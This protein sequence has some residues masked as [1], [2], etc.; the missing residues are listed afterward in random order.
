MCLCP[1]TIKNPHYDPC[2]V[3]TE[4][5]C[6]QRK[7][8]S[9]GDYAVLQSMENFYNRHNTHICVPCGKCPECKLARSNEFVQRCLM[10]SI[11]TYQFMFTLTY[12]SNHLPELVLETPFGDSVSFT[13]AD[14]SDITAMFKRIRTLA[15]RG[16]LISKSFFDNSAYYISQYAIQYLRY[17]VVSERGS[18]RHRPHFHGIIFI[19]Q[20]ICIDGNSY[21]VDP[22]ITENVLYDAL[23]NHFA[24]NIGTR[25]NPIY[26]KLF[27]FHYK[28]C[29]GQIKKN[30]DLHY[31]I[32]D[33]VSGTSKVI[34]YVSKYIIKDDP[35]LDSIKYQLHQYREY[36]TDEELNYYYIH[37][38]KNK[39]VTSKY[40]GLGSTFNCIDIHNY[41]SKC[42]KDSLN[43]KQRMP[44]FYNFDGKASQMCGYYRHVATVL[45]ASRIKENSPF[46]FIA[47]DPA[48]KDDT[49]FFSLAD[50]YGFYFQQN[51]IF[52]DKTFEE[53]DEPELWSRFIQIKNKF[54]KMSSSEAHID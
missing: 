43:T 32:P 18:K 46:Y 44:M 19:P 40:F 41:L 37:Y 30:F 15:N 42:V 28:L 49:M 51:E 3:K 20:T 38:L 53:A 36:Y 16:Q 33:S 2:Y 34:Y 22:Y 13:Y 23:F 5:K 17:A 21:S 14:F 10:E 47:D 9:A 7:P 4:L 8:L 50:H 39:I 11:N 6:L 54:K 12:D 29:A 48:F 27:T 52:L 35:Y 24:K 26:E 45:P 25:K 1:I 31:I